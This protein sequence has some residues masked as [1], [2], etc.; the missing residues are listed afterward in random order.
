MKRLHFISVVSLLGLLLVVYAAV[1]TTQA[2]ES[3][4]TNCASQNYIVQEGDNLG[5]IAWQ[6]GIT[7][8][9]LLDAND[10]E[11]HN[12]YHVG[13]VLVIPSSGC[14]SDTTTCGSQTYTVQEGDNL[15]K[16]AWQFGITLQEL[17][18]ANDLQDHND[19]H[20]G[21]VL[22]IP[23][24]DCPQQT[25]FSITQ[26]E[27]F[28]ITGS[29]DSAVA[30][31]NAGLKFGSYLSWSV[32]DVGTLLP[33]VNTSWQ[34]IRL[35][36]N[37]VKTSY[38]T[39]DA[40]LES[41]PGDTWII[42]NEPDVIWQDN[43]TAERYA[44]LYNELYHYIKAKDPTA[45]VAIGAVSTPTPLR[46]AY[47]DNVLKSYKSNYGVSL[48]VDVWTLHAYVL[49]EERN[50]WG[51]EIPPGMTDVNAGNLYEI[52]EHNDVE[53]ITRLITEFRGWMAR[54]GYQDVP[55]AIT[56][57]GIL[58]PADFGF[59]PSVV[60]EYM[61]GVVGF[62]L[63]SADPATGYSLDNNHLVQWWF[64]FSVYDDAG[65]FNVSDLYDPTNFTL[66]QLG[67]AYASYIR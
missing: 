46:R 45:K 57:F 17:L 2:A 9:E 25:G 22:V 8:Q 12:D 16:I 53:E 63:N 55:L 36:Q 67:W 20:V 48:P 11:D 50:S 52:D 4:T 49:R 42:G 6:F 58:M 28:G 38:K 39:I 3:N 54:N 27:R 1:T 18:D 62:L 37:G 44:E 19:Y 10:L 59:P 64:W 32:K 7:L 29:S 61:R 65:E 34:T 51:V 13:Q 56:E 26:R 24:A 30:A 33:Q 21:Q 47:L 41:R 5:K 31:Y 43:V 60:A 15:G 35:S 66:T 14:S 40:V 23:S